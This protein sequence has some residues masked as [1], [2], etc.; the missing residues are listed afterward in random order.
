ML[1]DLIQIGSSRGIRI[2]KSVLQ[3]CGMI[4]HLEMKIDRSKIILEPVKSTRAGWR[5][6]FAKNKKEQEKLDYFQNE[7]DQNEWRW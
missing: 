5:D 7:F 1:I 6:A 4:D 2:P 3:Q